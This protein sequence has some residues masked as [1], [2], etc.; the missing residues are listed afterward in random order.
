MKIYD[1]GVNDGSGIPI[2]ADFGDADV[3][4]KAGTKTYTPNAVPGYDPATRDWIATTP[5]MNT[6]AEMWTEFEVQ[7]DYYREKVVNWIR[8]ENAARLA[9]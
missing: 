6:E 4:F 8:R 7:R 5:A 1:V 2:A 9:E 3:P